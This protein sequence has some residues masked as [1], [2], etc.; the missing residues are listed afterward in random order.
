MAGHEFGGEVVL[1]FFKVRLPLVAVVLALLY[2]A[3]QTELNDAQKLGTENAFYTGELAEVARLEREMLT[4]VNTAQNYANGDI[5]VSREDMLLSFDL[6]WARVNTVHSKRFIGRVDELRTYEPFIVSLSKK[7]REVD[8]AV[9]AL[10]RKD[11]ENLARINAVIQPSIPDVS[12]F[13]ATAFA[14][15]QRRSLNQT[16]LQR[17]AMQG[18]YNVQ[19]GFLAVASMSMLY[20]LYQLYRDKK[21]LAR[22]RRREKE[23]TLLATTDY[24]TGLNNRREFENLLAAIDDDPSSHNHNLLLIDLDGFKS[25]NDTHGHATGDAVLREVAQR[26]KQVADDDEKLARLGGDEFAV[27]MRSSNEDAARRASDIVKAMKAPLVIGDK[28]I[29]L[30]A[31]VGIASKHGT[32]VVMM[33]DADIALYRAKEAGRSRF[34]Y[35]SQDLMDLA[36]EAKR[37]PSAT[38]S[39]KPAK[40]G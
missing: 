6:I 14:E 39:M 8:P 2:L 37:C 40:T 24:L 16:E 11:T 12:K 26:L 13:T 23:I 32:S 10:G 4:F 25:V 36:A 34:F 15:L 29:T 33:H 18:L 38:S 20:L 35:F 28:T 21:L 7:L 5:Q 9:Q 1:S 17:R 22:L 19:V 27:L 31:S 30:G 3:M